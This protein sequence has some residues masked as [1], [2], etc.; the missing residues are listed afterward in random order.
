MADFPIFKTKVEGLN[1]K[2][3]LNDPQERKKYFE[4]KAGPELEKLRKYLQR[5]TFIGF[6]L[7]K[8]NSGKGTYSKLFME[9]V[10][11]PNIAH[12]SVGDVVRDV[13]KS[14]ADAGNRAQLL[15]FLKKN[16]RGYHSTRETISLIEGRNT[17]SLISSELI[18]AL[19]EYEISK[20]PRTALF[21]DGFPRAIDQ[22]SYSFFLKDIVGYR[23][24]PDFFVFIS[25]PEAIIDERI[26]YRVVC[27][28][29]QTPRNLKLLAT[30]EVGYDSQKEEFYLKCDNPTCGGERMVRKEGDELGIEPVRPR[31]EVDDQVL[32][33]LMRV[34]GIP[35]IY[36]RNAIP[37]DVARDYVDDYEITPAYEYQLDSSGQ[38]KILEKPW[39][40]KDDDGVD[41]YSLLPPA[42][43]V[44][45]IK[46]TVSTLFP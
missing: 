25:L 43:V 31:L 38:V 45:L 6:L 44:S 34:E 40:V 15:E 3:N 11:S 16:Y 14:L 30:K 24:D 46:Q 32:K 1:L 27:P 28:I 18:I 20:R 37:A 29:C 17:S 42:V 4:S 2:F 41:S 21:I 26:K 36:L 13:H 7:G 8:K 9:A 5:N 19:M 39:T 33:Q 23:D 12:L 10:S 35:K 22:I